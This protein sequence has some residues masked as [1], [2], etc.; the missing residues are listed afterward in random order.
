MSVQN[1][2]L[3]S[4]CENFPRSLGQW[5]STFS[6]HDPQHNHIWTGDPPPWQALG[7][8]RV[9]VIHLALLDSTDKTYI[10]DLQALTP[11]AVSRSA[12]LF[13]VKQVWLLKYTHGMMTIFG[14]IWILFVQKIFVWN[15]FPEGLHLLKGNLFWT[16]F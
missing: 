16:W 1:K 11:R 5:F 4:R 6:D 15:V 12:I 7:I 2:L 8:V 10:A 9:Q 3:Q 13:F 14:L